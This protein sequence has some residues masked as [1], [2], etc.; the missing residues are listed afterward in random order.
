MGSKSLSSSFLASITDDSLN[1]CA[2]IG[3]M[4]LGT[5]MEDGSWRDIPFLSTA[6]SLYKIGNSIKERH[7]LNENQNLRRI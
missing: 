4:G 3:E 5:F 7:H 6:V 1:I 2:N